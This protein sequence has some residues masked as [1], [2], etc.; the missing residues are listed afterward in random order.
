M[1]LLC[2]FC[3]SAKMLQ[4]KDIFCALDARLEPPSRLLQGQAI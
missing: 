2:I 3:I 4:Y 1:R